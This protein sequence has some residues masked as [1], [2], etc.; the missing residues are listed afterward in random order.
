MHEYNI[1][2][3]LDG[4][5]YYYA[6]GIGK[7]LNGISMVDKGYDGTKYPSIGFITHGLGQL[8]DDIYGT[9]NLQGK[10]PSP[11]VGFNNPHPV[12]IFKFHVRRKFSMIKFH[13]LNKGQH[14]KVFS[15]VEIEVS[16]DGKNF[17]RPTVYSSSSAERLSA[18]AFK[19]SVGLGR[20]VCQYIKAKFTQ[21]GSWIAISEVDFSSG[22]CRDILLIE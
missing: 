13:T 15:K 12:L 19:I 21:Q 22:R 2:F 17:T 14:I 6:S 1:L 11:W 7:V 3:F 10:S 8:T 4:L 20:V 18:G 16:N 5:A 9:S